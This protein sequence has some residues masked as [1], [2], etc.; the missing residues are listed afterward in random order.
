MGSVGIPQASPGMAWRDGARLSTYFPGRPDLMNKRRVYR[1]VSQD[2]I[3]WTDPVL[4]SGPDDDI[5]NLDTAHYGIGQ[6]RV[7]GTHFGTLGVFRYVDNEMEVRLIY[8][9]DG[10]NWRPTDNGAPFLAPRGGGHWDRHMVS[11]VSP[12]VR[13]GDSWYF[14]HGG[15]W[16]HHDYWWA[17]PYHQ[18]DH[19]EAREPEKHVR[20]GLGIAELRFEGMAS[21]DAVRPRPGRLVTKPVNVGAGTLKINARARP[22]GSIRVAVC[23]SNGAMLPGYTLDDSLPFTGDAVRHECRWQGGAALPATG[24]GVFRKLVFAVDGAEIFGFVVDCP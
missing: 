11:I 9:H 16:C 13:V 15:S 5:D 3:H 2:F 6:F 4:I 18:L 14:Y 24:H 20:F 19:E 17:G 22:N 21:L 10:V 1:T 8:S 7:G 12:P 23:D